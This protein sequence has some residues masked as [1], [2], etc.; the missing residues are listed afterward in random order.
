M[1]PALQQQLRNELMDE[2]IDPDTAAKVTVLLYMLVQ[3]SAVDG[4]WY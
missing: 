2:G 1:L 3:Q 4:R